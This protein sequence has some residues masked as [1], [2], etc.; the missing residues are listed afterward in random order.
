[1][2]MPGLGKQGGEEKIVMT[3][4][5]KIF[6]VYNSLSLSLS[7]SLQSDLQWSGEMHLDTEFKCKYIYLVLMKCSEIIVYSCIIMS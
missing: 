7:L 5:L 2:G 6:D 4:F 1:M 3:C